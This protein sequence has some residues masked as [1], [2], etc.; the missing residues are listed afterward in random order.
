MSIQVPILSAQQVDNKIHLTWQYPQ[1]TW[2]DAQGYIYK[3]GENSDKWVRGY[4]TYGSYSNIIKNADNIQVSASDWEY[5]VDLT[6]INSI[7]IDWR[8]TLTGS[9]GN[10][11]LVVSTNKIASLGTYN[12]RILKTNVS[13]SRLIETLNVS[14]LSG[15]YYIRVHSAT[16]SQGDDYT[17][18]FW[19]IRL[20]G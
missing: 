3:E 6:S 10:A 9:F 15:E 7:E 13:F 5:G 12:A 17:T 18:T 8:G 19:S 4:S 16:G 11:A 1:P 20:L 2:P 14:G